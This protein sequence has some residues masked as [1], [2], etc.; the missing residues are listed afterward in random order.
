[1]VPTGQKPKCLLSVIHTTKA[2]H[3]RHHFSTVFGAF[4]NPF[5]HNIFLESFDFPLRAHQAHY[6]P[7]FW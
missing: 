7:T 6:Y 5:L 1:M 2:I 4:K 3:H